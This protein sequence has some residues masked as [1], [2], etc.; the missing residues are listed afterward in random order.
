VTFHAIG[1][2]VRE[3]PALAS[4]AGQPTPLKILSMS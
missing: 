1:T 2:V 3:D 4:A